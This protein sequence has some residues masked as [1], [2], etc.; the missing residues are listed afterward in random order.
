MT[1][2]T[3]RRILLDTNVIIFALNKTSPKNKTAQTY[4]RTNQP[5][6]VVAHQNV[7]ESIRVLSHSKYAKPLTSAKAVSVVL[8]ITSALKLVSP[9]IET[10]HQTLYLIKKYKLTSNK[11]F[12]CY[13]VATALSNNIKSIATDNAKDFLIFE[14]ISTVNPFS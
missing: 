8:D 3:S 9:N 6:L 4:I 7:F 5:S 11:I 12:D 1:F 13:L 2:M 14:E 10:F